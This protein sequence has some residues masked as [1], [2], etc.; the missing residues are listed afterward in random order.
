M[1][2]SC[3]RVV[4]SLIYCSERNFLICCVITWEDSYNLLAVTVPVRYTLV[5][6]KYL[7]AHA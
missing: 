6:T 5:V 7:L 1:N 4:L 3:I 2:E